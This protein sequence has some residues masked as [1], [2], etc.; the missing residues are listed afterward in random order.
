MFDRHDALVSAG[1]S[2]A[3]ETTNFDG[4]VTASEGESGGQTT[5]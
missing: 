3:V 5:R 4:R 1:D 2:Y